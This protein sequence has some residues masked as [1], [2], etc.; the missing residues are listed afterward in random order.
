[1]L[2]CSAPHTTAEQHFALVRH[3][4]AI[5][6]RIW[7][8]LTQFLFRAR[9]K[10]RDYREWVNNFNSQEFATTTPSLKRKRSSL[11]PSLTLQAQL[12]Y[13]QVAGN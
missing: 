9:G 5:R 12:V 10:Q 6:E 4:L 11:W 7:Q 2:F 1:M 13:S 8:R 3:W